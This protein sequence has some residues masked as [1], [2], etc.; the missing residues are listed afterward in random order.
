MTPCSAVRNDPDSPESPLPAKPKARGEGTPNKVVEAPVA[1]A[2]T[3]DQEAKRRLWIAIEQVVDGQE[4]DHALVLGNVE[5]Q[6][7]VCVE[8]LIDMVMCGKTINL[9]KTFRLVWQ[10]AATYLN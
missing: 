1:E 6:R 5:G 4:T 8:H 9:R 3:G 10:L 7:R 2:G